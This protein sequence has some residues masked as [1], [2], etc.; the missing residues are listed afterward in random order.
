M[1]SA[2]DVEMKDATSD[3]NAPRESSN[4]TL[5]DKP[6]ITEPK[7][8][9]Q[10]AEVVDPG[11]PQFKLR[12]LLSGHKRAVSCLKFSPDGAFLASACM[13]TKSL[14]LCFALETD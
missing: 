9:L 11:C 6:N 12:F 14:D 4:T 2:G 13:S 7:H 5:E 10:E 3:S 1:S 8:E